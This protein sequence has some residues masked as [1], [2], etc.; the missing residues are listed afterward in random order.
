MFKDLYTLDKW[1]DIT[2]HQKIGEILLSAGKINLI[3]LSMA[4][5]AQR[6]KK[7]PLGRL[8]VLMHIISQEDLEQTLNVQKY[9]DNRISVGAV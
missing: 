7:F 8:F 6:F 9:I 3:H 1:N 5:D 4:L 2:E